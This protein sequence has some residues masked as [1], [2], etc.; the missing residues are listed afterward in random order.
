MDSPPVPFSDFEFNFD[1]VLHHIFPSPPPLPPAAD[2]FT[3]SE[4][5]DIL[6]FLDNF[7]WEFDE[8]EQATAATEDRVT[9]I[10]PSNTL[11][12]STNLLNNVNHLSHPPLIPPP[13][14]APSTTIAPTPPVVTNPNGNSTGKA[15][16]SK[17]KGQLSAP[18]K[19]LNHIMSE[20]KRR[21][22]IRDGYVQ[23]TALL[24]PAG[25]PPGTGMPTRGRPKGSGNRGKGK[26]QGK[27][28]ILFRAV[29]YCHFMEENIQALRDEVA[30]LEAAAAENRQT[31]APAGG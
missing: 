12:L 21:N 1:P 6:G 5:T 3:Q 16:T 4:T 9:S 31:L 8:T 20:Q 2:L 11:N 18:Q 29:D 7:N 23:L 14:P 28:G 15:A 24:A 17:T 22:A 25:A 13:L 10:A 26:C 27:S 19:R 30:K